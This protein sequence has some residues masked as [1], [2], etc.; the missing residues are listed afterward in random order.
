MASGRGAPRPQPAGWRSCP[1]AGV[2]MRRTILAAA[3]LSALAL[4][5]QAQEIP[6]P[7]DV[8]YAPG[9][10]A[11]EVDATNLGQ[12]IFR[13]KETIPVQAGPLVLLYPEWLPGNHSPR[14]P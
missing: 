11:V 1:F 4:S 9:P 12:R 5:A 14:G 7:Q 10:I 3:L 8:P 2:A 13:V 6:S